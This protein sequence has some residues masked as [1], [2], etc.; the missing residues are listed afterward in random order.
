MPFLWQE[1]DQLNY[2][3]QH[4]VLQSASLV[5]FVLEYIQVI[6]GSYSNNALH[7]VPGCVKD[8]LIEVQTVHANLVFLSLTPCT[9]FP[10]LQAGSGFAV[11]SWGFQCN[12]PSRVSVKHSEE[13]VVGPRHNGTVQERKE[14]TLSTSG[15][16][17]E[18]QTLPLWVPISPLSVKKC[19]ADSSVNF[20]TYFHVQ[21]K[22]HGSI[23]LNTFLQWPEE[24]V[25]SPQWVLQE[26]VICLTR[27]LGTECL[28]LSQLN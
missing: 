8:L 26:V 12:I 28:H 24:S 21:G 18:A 9:Y 22:S 5:N 19:S 4:L 3:R 2:A 10:G 1:N 25:R 20:I 6:G 11:L 15:V 14:G 27:G 13:V 17:H 7:G 23:I 16:R